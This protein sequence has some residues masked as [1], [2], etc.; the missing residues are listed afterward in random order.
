MWSIY[1]RLLLHQGSL[2]YA[3]KEVTD[4]HASNRSRVRVC[5]TSSIMLNWC[6]RLFDSEGRS[7][8]GNLR[9]ILWPN[10]AIESHLNSAS[11][12]CSSIYNKWHFF[13][14]NA[15]DLRRVMYPVG[16]FALVMQRHVI[17]LKSR[18]CNSTSCR[19][20]FSVVHK[21]LDKA[22]LMLCSFFAPVSGVYDIMHCGGV[23]Y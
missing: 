10:S 6:R 20:L 12:Y 9:E 5:N 18:Q 8:Q 1:P 17:S 4:Q 2:I 16:L 21:T 19:L 3:K 23:E 13:I 22:P 11:G 14:M 15:L 7:Y